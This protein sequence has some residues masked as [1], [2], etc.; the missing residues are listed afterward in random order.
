[1]SDTVASGDESEAVSGWW[2]SCGNTVGADVGG[3]IGLT[4]ENVGV[5]VGG[6]G[7][8]G[9]TDGIDELGVAVGEIEVKGGGSDKSWTLPPSGIR[10]PLTLLVLHS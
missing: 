8:V 9:A 2:L 1:M 4:G 3:A 6:F 7:G 10:I 5:S